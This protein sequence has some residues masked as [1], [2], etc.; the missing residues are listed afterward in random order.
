MLM[1]IKGPKRDN[2]KSSHT[3]H[4]HL[5]PA[6]KRHMTELHSCGSLVSF[7]CESFDNYESC[8]LGIDDRIALYVKG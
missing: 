7:D 3:W 5:H 2:M 1:T 4:C 6:N 8:L